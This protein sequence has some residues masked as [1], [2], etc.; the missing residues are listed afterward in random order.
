MATLATVLTFS[1]AQSQTDNNG[2]TDTNGIIFANEA[3]L[4]FRRR[5]IDAGVDAAQT[6]ESYTDTVAGTGT[7]LYPSDMFWLKAIEL[8]Y[9]NTNAR[10][11]KTASQVDASNMPTGESFSSLRVNASKG[12]PMFD[13]RGDQYEIYPTP[14]AADNTTAAVRIFYF[15]EPTEYTATSDS[16]SYPESLDNRTIGWRVASNYLYSLGKIPEGDAFNMKY[17]ERVKQLIETLSR[18]SQQPIKPTQLPVT[19]WEF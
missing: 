16:I 17:E 8:N 15:L 19:G 10:D 3:L 6:Q 11:Y 9:S 7:Y 18:G 13:D 5:L 14:V 2:L 12:S 1:R 4:D